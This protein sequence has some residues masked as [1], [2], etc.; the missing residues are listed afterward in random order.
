MRILFRFGDA[1]LLEPLLGNPFADRV[2]HVFFREKYMHAGVGRIVGRHR[3][4]EQIQRL[5]SFGLCLR[6]H[7]RQFF[8]TIIAE[9]DENDRVARA[10]ATD[11]MPSASTRT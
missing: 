10:N 6:E 2:G 8:S 1:Q 9:I 7:R 3:G 11:R 5:H 4:K